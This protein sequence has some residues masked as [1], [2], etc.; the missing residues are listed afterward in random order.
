MRPTGSGELTIYSGREQGPVGPLL[1]RYAKQ[2]GVDIKGALRHGLWVVTE[3]ERTL[4][5][6]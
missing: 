6:A 1:D 3:Q 5:N 4:T 2:E